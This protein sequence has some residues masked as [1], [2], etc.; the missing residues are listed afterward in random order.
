MICGVSVMEA[1]QIA[2]LTFKGWELVGDVW[3]KE[4]FEYAR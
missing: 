1:H 2:Y 3:T 4:G